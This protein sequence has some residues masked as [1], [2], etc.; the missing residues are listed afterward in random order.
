M[1]ASET[2]LL[3]ARNIN[4]SEPRIIPDKISSKSDLRVNQTDTPI[5]PE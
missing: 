2:M 1:N 5:N 4:Y 3:F